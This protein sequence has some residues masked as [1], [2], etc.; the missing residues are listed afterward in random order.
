MSIGLLTMNHRIPRDGAISCYFKDNV[1]DIVFTNSN[2]KLFPS[3]FFFNRDFF[4][5]C[6]SARAGKGANKQQMKQSFLKLEMDI[7]L[8]GRFVYK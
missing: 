5:I 6:P 7:S 2:L 3:V 4:I 1:Q 8:M